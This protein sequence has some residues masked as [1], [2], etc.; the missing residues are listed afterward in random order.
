M[1]DAGRSHFTIVVVVSVV[2]ITAMVSACSVIT[3]GGTD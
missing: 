2:A 3:P 1:R